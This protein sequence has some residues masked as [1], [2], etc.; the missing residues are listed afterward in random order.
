VTGRSA[1]AE[2][3]DTR[4]ELALGLL[5]GTDRAAAVAHLAGCQT[6]R[7]EVDDIARVVDQLALLAPQAEPPPGFETR[8]LAA[9]AGGRVGRGGRKR[10]RPG[11]RL[12]AGRAAAMVAVALVAI[13]WVVAIGLVVGLN[14]VRT[15]DRPARQSAT[16]SVRTA[17]AV[18]PSGRT[19]CR[20]VVTGTRPATVVVSLDA[21]PGASG[22]YTV[23]VQQAGGPTIE[24]G[25]L[26]LA[27]GHGVLA[28]SVPVDAATLTTMLMY[29]ED[30]KL[31]YEEH[32][33]DQV[34]TTD[35]HP[36]GS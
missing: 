13:G 20:V 21:P 7:E 29:G 19:T 24:L 23:A 26:Q 1:C 9:V 32:L 6:C 36:V 8:V 25:A 14:V 5:S 11:A 18:S 27:D 35:S 15:D 4:V 16:P 34:V 22:A 31:L 10:S 3:A 12:V 17:L 2:L 30:G 33:T 28:R